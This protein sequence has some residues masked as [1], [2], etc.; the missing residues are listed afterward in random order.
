M[1]FIYPNGPSRLTRICFA[2]CSTCPLSSFPL[3]EKK[4][5]RDRSTHTH[6]HTCTRHFLFVRSLKRTQ[7]VVGWIGYTCFCVWHAGREFVIY[8]CFFLLRLNLSSDFHRCASLFSSFSSLAK[9]YS[10]SPWPETKNE[11]CDDTKC[12]APNTG[13][14]SRKKKKTIFLWHLIIE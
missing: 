9:F 6:T 13:C 12:V 3:T 8:L 14:K 10:T 7:N 1:L 2:V 4:K 11:K 5:K